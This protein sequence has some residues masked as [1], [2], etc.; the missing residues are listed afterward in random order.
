[1]TT[2]K[3][4]NRN[5]PGRATKAKP[6][7]RRRRK[8]APAARPLTGKQEAF[9]RLYTSALCN[10][11]G[12]DAARR[13]GYKGAD[14]QLAVVASQ[15]LT[16]LNVAARIQI[17]TDEALSSANITIEKVLRDIEVARVGA[18]EAGKFGPA[19]RGAELHGKYLKMW[20]DKIEHVADYEDMGL[21]E[22]QKLLL[23]VAQ[24]G[25]VDLSELLAGN[26]S[27]DGVLL[28]PAKDPT[29]H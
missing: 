24:A 2:K 4:D 28:D 20:T 25:G 15:N 5:R 19:V 22:L 26:G 6:R 18:L 13:A 23:E 3:A 29:K 12:L 10:F 27:G 14:N 11:N 17:L 1:M 9:C 7:P 21:D 8:V 16:K